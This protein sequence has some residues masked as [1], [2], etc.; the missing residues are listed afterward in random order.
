MC[1]WVCKTFITFAAPTRDLVRNPA[2]ISFK[3]DVD[4][5]LPSYEEVVKNPHKYSLNKP[6][7]TTETV[8]HVDQQNLPSYKEALLM[9][10]YRFIWSVFWLV[11]F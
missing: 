1:F 10:P 5:G 4:E 11:A 8:V 3:V 2:S 9:W 6:M 7:T